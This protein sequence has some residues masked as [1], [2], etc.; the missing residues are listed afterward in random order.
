MKKKKEQQKEEA[1]VESPNFEELEEVNTEAEAAEAVLSETEKLAAELQDQRE[2]L[3]YLQADYQN[4]R[5]R[6]IKE[7]TDARMIGV[8]STLDPFL[9][10]FDYLMM[11][12]GAAEKS[13]NIESIRQGIT[14]IIDEYVKAFDDLGVKRIESIGKPFD[15][16]WQEAV[17]QQPS[18]TVPEGV[19]IREWSP[20][21]KLGEKVLRVA[22]V[23]V[24]SGTPKEEPSETEAT[25]AE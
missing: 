20:A 12:K 11:A 22:K 8:S 10:V 4:Y 21:Y 13:D 24:S 6:M 14:M 23:V 16:E 25:D 2:K 5:K 7:V 18:E 19:V 3:L 9:R 15:P 17:Q 1:K